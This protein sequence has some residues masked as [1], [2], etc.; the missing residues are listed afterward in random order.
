MKIRRLTGRERFILAI[1]VSLIGLGLAVDLLIFPALAGLADLDRDIENKVMLIKKY[2]LLKNKG[3]DIVSLYKNYGLLSETEPGFEDAANH[4]F[5]EIRA[6]AS[7]QNL[8]IKK[9]KPFSGE[10]RGPYR[11]IMLEL[12]LAGDF[13]S[14]FQ[15]ADDLE[16]QSVLIKVSSLR[17]TAQDQ[18]PKGLQCSLVL[19][20][21]FFDD[22]QEKKNKT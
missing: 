9:V 6:L 16:R 15:F 7:K 12:E 11:R 17:L 2:S 4:L 14:L 8:E 22:G 13:N 21:F 5:E 10:S 19:C 3:E 1:A 20:R 18:Q